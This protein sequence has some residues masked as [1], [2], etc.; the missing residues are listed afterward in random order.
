VLGHLREL[1][2]AHW[3][4]PDTT[5]RAFDFGIKG[6]PQFSF[7]VQI[8][9][10][11]QFI[12][13]RVYLPRLLADF[14]ARGGTV[15]QSGAL[16]PAAVA[17]L[18]EKH[19]LVVVASGRSELAGLFPR[20]PERSP[21]TTPQRR[22][23]A[24]LFH[25]LRFPAERCFTQRLV[26]GVGEICEF[27]LLTHD[28]PV[29][30]LLIFA[31][32]GGALEGITHQR[33]EDDPAAF[34]RAVFD[35]LREHAPAICER[36]EDQAGFGALGPLE[37]LQGGIV[38]VVRH[39]VCELSPGRHALALGDAHVTMDPLT[40]QGANAAAKAAYL[41]SGILAERIAEGAALDRTFCLGAE[42]RLWELVQPASDWNNAALGPPAP[43][44]FSIIAA[45]AQNPAIG[46]EFAANFDDPRR[47]WEILNSPENTAAFINR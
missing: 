10:P 20:V 7:H 46:S 39:G 16:D 21:Y 30:A 42:Q 17:R 47:Q 44:V 32:P 12:D 23:L 18:G 24:G 6:M 36:I 28:G 13:M 9:K 15:V 14:T 35:L 22:I 33:Y 43:H 19:E 34:N 5:T 40:A 26:A 4:E 11:M 1:G 38:P 37:L 41:L 2:V 45:A 29:S 27:Q 8:P 25:G 31:V 3:E